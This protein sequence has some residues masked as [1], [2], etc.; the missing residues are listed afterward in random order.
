MK[1][2][3]RSVLAVRSPVTGNDV[4]NN[5]ANT[6]MPANVPDPIPQGHPSIVRAG[7]KDFKIW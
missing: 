2:N 4:E 6:R 1:P 5:S 7:R 3:R